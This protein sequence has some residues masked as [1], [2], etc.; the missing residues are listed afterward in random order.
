[1]NAR[2]NEMETS[3]LPGNAAIKGENERLPQS[4]KPASDTLHGDFGRTCY[5]EK[6]LQRPMEAGCY[7]PTVARL[8]LASPVAL[9]GP[10]LRHQPCLCV[11]KRSVLGRA[12]S[13]AVQDALQQRHDEYHSCIS[14]YHQLGEP[15][16]DERLR[17]TIDEAQGVDVHMLQPGLGWIPWWQ[18]EVYSA[19]DHYGYYQRE[20]GIKPNSFGRYLLAGGDLVQTFVE[21][22]RKI[23][24]V[25]FISYRLN[26]GHHYARSGRV[27]QARSTH[28]RQ[29]RGSTGRT[30][31]DTASGPT[32][33]IGARRSSIGRFPKCGSTS[34]A[35]SERSAPTTISPD[36]NWTSCVTG[37]TLT[38][39]GLRPNSDVRL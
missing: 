22:C 30:T 3:A 17:A 20:Y 23:G 11:R 1:M 26:D 6:R 9:R 18:S 38:S 7:A 28:R 32:R 27:A 25:P 8:W 10:C 36:S 16:S 4:A 14:P 21:H 19:E 33:T 24:V 2:K 37:T 12:T 31:S 39:R 34:S 35:S 15:I 5:F 13:S 29:C